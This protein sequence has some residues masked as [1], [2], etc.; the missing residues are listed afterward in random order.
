MI[1]V[2]GFVV[3][4][5]LLLGVV[6]FGLDEDNLMFNGDILIVMEIVVLV[7]MENV[8]IIYFGWWFWFDEIQV[9]QMDDFDNLGMIGVENVVVDWEIVDGFVG[10]FCVSCYGGFEE[11][12]GLCVVYLKW[13][14][15]KGKVMIL[16]MEIN[17]CCEICM[18]VEKWKYIGGDMMDMVVLI[19]FVFCGLLVNVVIDGLVKDIWEQGKEFYYMWI[20]QLEMFCVNCYEDS[21]GMMIWV[22]YLSQG[23]I[24]GFLI[25]WLK[26]IKFNFVYVWF[27]GC[28]CDMC[29]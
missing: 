5:V 2:I 16:E 4:L 24:N 7:Y 28:V 12:V 25:Y 9:F 11:M 23:Q 10:K 15:D 27:K 22:D 17:D 20:G 18:G 6:M 29:V 21:Y 1:I 8:L 26:N 19:F 13:N 14:V 3:V